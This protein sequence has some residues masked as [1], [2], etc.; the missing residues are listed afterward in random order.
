MRDW[1]KAVGAK[2]AYIEPG[3]LW[4]NFNGRMRDELLNGDIFCSLR[5]AQTIERWRNHYKTIRPHSAL[6]A[7]RRQ[8]LSEYLSPTTLLLLGGGLGSTCFALDRLRYGRSMRVSFKPGIA[9]PGIFD[10]SLLCF[11]VDQL[12]DDPRRLFQ[13]RFRSFRLLFEY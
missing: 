2:T 3:S 1:I 13:R 10:V 11:F 9:K 8:K 7:P 6:W 4:E 5:E 12:F